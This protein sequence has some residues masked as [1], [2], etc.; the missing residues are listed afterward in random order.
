MFA[1]LK[2]LLLGTVNREH[3]IIFFADQ[4]T[5]YLQPIPAASAIPDW[6]KNMESY[7]G[8]KT[9]ENGVK[10]INITNGGDNATIKR[11]IPVLDSMS[12]GY[13]IVTPADIYVEPKHVH[14]TN[15]ENPTVVC[16]F[17]GNGF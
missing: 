4:E 3:P 2:K 11:C 6:W 12:I 15:S 7:G 14:N 5:D 13:L 9:Y 8:F 10:K 16:C 17:W 1:K